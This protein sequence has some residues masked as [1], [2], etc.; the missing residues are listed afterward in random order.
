M[1]SYI[2]ENLQITKDLNNTNIYII[3]AITIDMPRAY[4]PS[5]TWSE[6]RSAREEAIKSITAF[7]LIM[8]SLSSHAQVDLLK[9][10]NHTIVQTSQT[11]IALDDPQDFIALNNKVIFRAYDNIHGWEIWVTDNTHDGTYLLKD[12]SGTSSEPTSFTFLNGFVYFAAG[13]ESNGRELWKTDGTTAGTVLV[14]DINPGEGTGLR[15]PDFM[16]ELNGDLYFI[17]DDGTG[18]ALWKSDGTALGTSKIKS[19]T[20]DTSSAGPFKFAKTGNTLFIN[21]FDDE[22]GYE[23]WRSDGTA[24]GTTI[25]KDLVPGTDF[26]FPR[27][28]TTLNTD[29]FFVAFSPAQGKL[30]LWKS[31]GT[32]DG[33]SAIQT[34]DSETSAYPAELTSGAGLIFF[35]SDDGLT[36]RELWRTDG[37]PAGTFMIN[38]KTSWDRVAT[39]PVDVNGTVY[40]VSN[41]GNGN[42]LWKTDGTVVGTV[43]VKDIHNGPLSSLPA[44]LTVV[45]DLLYFVANDGINGEALWQSDGTEQGTKLEKVIGANSGIKNIINVNESLFFHADDGT[46]S[47]TRLWSYDPVEKK[48]TNLGY[49]FTYSTD[50]SASS[51]PDDFIRVNETVYFGA[52]DG[53]HGFELWKSDGTSSGTS[54]VKDITPGIG[55]SYFYDLTPADGLL[56]FTVDDGVHGREMWKTDGTTEGT[57]MVKDIEPGPATSYP[58]YLAFHNGEVY[59][60]AEAGIDGAELWKTDGTETGTVMVKD[61]YPGDWNSSYPYNLTS[62]GNT[63]YFVAN[64]DIHFTGLGIWKTDGTAE[65]TVI[66]NSAD[67]Q[68]GAVDYP[69]MNNRYLKGMNGMLYFKAYTPDVGHELWKSDGTAEGTVLVKDINVGSASS[70]IEQFTELNGVL[71]FLANDGVGGDELWKTDGT[72]EGTVLVKDIYPG[73][74]S[75]YPWDLTTANNLLFFTA[76]NEQGDLYLWRTDGTAAGTFHIES[77]HPNASTKNPWRLIKGGEQIFFTSL[78]ITSEHLWR[79]DGTLCGTVLLT[80]EHTAGI[81]FYDLIFLNDKVLFSGAIPG[82]EYGTELYAY[83]VA[84][85][86]P[87]RCQTISFDPLVT[88]KYGD[89]DFTLTASAGSGLPV[90]FSIADPSIISIQDNV[91]TILKSGSTTIIASQPGDASFNSAPAVSQLLVVEK[92]SLTASADD[93]TIFYGE[94]IPTLT[95]SY[96]GFKMLDD[97]TT[98]DSQPI[99]ATEAMQGS[100][101]ALYPVLLTGGSDENYT[102]TLVPGTLAINKAKQTINLS[103]SNKTLGELPFTVI[104]TATSELPVTLSTNSEKIN[105]SGQTITMLEAGNVTIYASQSGNEYFEAA[106]SIEANFC[107][108]PEKPI[109]TINGNNTATPIIESSSS[110]GNQWFLNSIAITND[111]SVLE[112]KEGGVYTVSVTHDNCTS[113]LSDPVSMIVTSIND[114]IVEKIVLSPNPT[115]EKLYV[116]LKSLQASVKNIS[117]LDAKGMIREVIHIQD[118][119]EE[120]EIDVSGYPSGPYI[121]LINSNNLMFSEKFIRR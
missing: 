102:I 52:D 20:F 26:G 103:I 2:R 96:S 59:F 69:W 3:D 83:Q 36:G 44:G 116:Q 85:M 71:Y 81:A 89:A 23:L 21:A 14:A 95:I 17:A 66:V 79:T 41:S 4:S 114:E 90:Q 16:T 35:T 18:D 7:V 65:G 88:K 55:D 101:P 108:N 82:S 53:I 106:P 12:L 76:T 99:A 38:K 62:V 13:T 98:I 31:D 10:I 110:S 87:S 47:H 70:S 64:D 117:I 107:I 121:L 57:V 34:I 30:N 29:I 91:V 45:E 6:N 42:E 68:I 28:M 120:V 61:I 1:F 73:S 22:H 27:T 9:D 104:A 48:A 112:V 54:L 33:T 109:L 77:N 50:F 11:T 58:Q 40:F 5:V 8:V 74:N 80:G 43:L 100:F 113:E 84:G 67:S 75:S 63:L 60:S 78:P 49:R 25:V 37:T 46:G 86:P 72:E 24:A 118:Q 97:E 15:F 111:Q 94:A 115:T 92:A 51:D 93:Q 39:S 105:L 32:T 19:M 56:F 119:L